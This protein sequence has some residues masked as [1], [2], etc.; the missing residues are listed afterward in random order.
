[1]YVY[2]HNSGYVV[3][4]DW[5]EPRGHW[6]S[7]ATLRPYQFAGRISGCCWVEHLH[8]QRQHSWRSCCEHWHRR[9]QILQSHGGQ[10]TIGWDFCP[11]PCANSKQ[12]KE[13]ICLPYLNISSDH[14]LPHGWGRYMLLHVLPLLL[15]VSRKRLPPP[16]NPRLRPD[17]RPLMTL[18]IR[19]S[20][21]W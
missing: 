1:M 3:K 20:S 6:D 14:Y 21:G 18:C 19:T 5:L 7:K 15:W 16:P 4:N 10:M 11:K 17:W 8:S 2:T 13:L 12:L 9:V